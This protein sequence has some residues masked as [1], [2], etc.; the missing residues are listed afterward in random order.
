MSHVRSHLTADDRQYRSVATPALP[1]LATAATVPPPEAAAVPAATNPG[2]P[3]PLRT[4]AACLASWRA[5]RRARRQLAAL[6]TRTCRDIGVAP[7]VVGY[8]ASQPFWRPLRK[9]WRD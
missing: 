3:A 2:W 8:E 9:N 4:I 1:P 7:E 6:D 5:R